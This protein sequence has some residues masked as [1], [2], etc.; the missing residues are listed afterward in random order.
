MK[1][2]VVAGMLL[3]SVQ[4][5][6]AQYYWHPYGNFY[7]HTPAAENDLADVKALRTLFSTPRSSA[8]M[9]CSSRRRRAKFFMGDSCISQRVCPLATATARSAATAFPATPLSTIWP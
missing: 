2:A 3:V 5:A 6:S 1:M 8:R 4:A 7:Y 9:H